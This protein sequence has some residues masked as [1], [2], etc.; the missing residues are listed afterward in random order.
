MPQKRAQVKGIGRHYRL[1]NRDAR[2][3]DDLGEKVQFFGINQILC[4]IVNDLQLIN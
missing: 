1:G 4:K 2:G 3:A